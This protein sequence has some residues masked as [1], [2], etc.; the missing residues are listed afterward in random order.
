MRRL[1]SFFLSFVIM[2]LV[3]TG[4]WAM[5]YPP[6]IFL[7][8]V[9]GPIAVEEGKI[10]SIPIFLLLGP[11]TNREV[12]F[13][14]WREWRGE[15][16]GIMAT[17]EYLDANLRWQPFEDAGSI[18]AL[19]KAAL[20]PYVQLNWQSNIFLL[21]FDWQT[22]PPPDG[23]SYMLYICLDARVDGQ[24]PTEDE[25]STN[26]P[27][28]VCAFSE[29]V[30]VP[31]VT[32]VCEPTSVRIEGVESG[33]NTRFFAGFPVF[34][35]YPLVSD[36]GA[37]SCRVISKPAF[38]TVSFENNN[39]RVDFSKSLTPGTYQGDIQISCEISNGEQNFTIPV[40]A[41]VDPVP[42]ECAG[43]LF[44]RDSTGQEYLSGATIY[45]SSRKTFQVMCRQKVFIV[46]GESVVPAYAFSW[47]EPC[48]TAENLNGSLVLT[49]LGDE[50]CTAH[51]DV[52]AG[53]ARV[54]YVV[55]RTEPTTCSPQVT[56]TSL[57]FTGSGTKT[58]YVKD[59]CGN[60]LSYR[61]VKVSK[62][63]ILDPKVGATGTGNLSVR[64]SSTDLPAGTYR[65]DIVIEL[66]GG[67]QVTINVILEVANTST[68]TPASLTVWP[69]EVDVSLEAGTRTTEVISATCSGRVPTSCSASKASGGDWLSVSGCD[70]AKIT[71]TLDTTGLT[72]GQTYTGA[73]S[74]NTSCGS[75]TVPVT[76]KVSGVCEATS[77]RVLP[78]TVSVSAQV[79]SSPAAK[80]IS[81]TDNCGRPL[82]FDVGEITYTPSTATGWLD[83]SGTEGKL[84]LNF[85]TDFLDE[86]TYKATIPVSTELGEATIT[87]ELAI[88][89]TPEVQIEAIRL[90]NRELYTG[91]FTG[92]QA[93]LFYF[94]AG[95][96]TI[97]LSVSVQAPSSYSTS[98]LNML[99]VNAGPDCSAD[100]PTVAQIQDLI[101]QYE[102]GAIASS[103]SSGSIYWNLGGNLVKRIQ[104]YNIDPTCWYLLVYNSSSTTY[105]NATVG[106]TAPR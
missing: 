91:T 25:F 87:V 32:S 38:V 10:P 57:P 27:Q 11:Y 12:E 28:A 43:T 89:D 63:W 85:S 15:A 23:L 100:P 94:T 59:S 49:P 98:Y 95:A 97:P 86:G 65:G 36:C 81:V 76:L 96:T 83:P 61:V 35:L 48:L 3:V 93:K 104:V 46:E 44:L 78:A 77:M 7:N 41:T 39:L 18:T 37:P 5:D 16:P 52:G 30:F 19:T 60:P 26:P 31:S 90:A 21:P 72:S 33:I 99:L 84:T 50:G 1:T 53:E 58:V 22:N 101:S 45:L 40:R 69:P 82:A 92:G 62:S 68:S 80:T 74:I 6:G 75:K 105:N 102:S 34:Y 14:V 13:F 4:A 71:V 73:V 51:F 54:S 88:S 9:P 66:E 67:D 103:G 70:G 29:V 17:K 2:A 55:K 56:P 106:F 8:N 47:D 42:G 20:P 24:P 64:V 79:G